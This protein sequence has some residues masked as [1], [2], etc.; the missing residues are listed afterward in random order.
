MSRSITAAAL[1]PTLGNDIVEHGCVL[2]APVR[3]SKGIH[4]ADAGNFID[5]RFTVSTNIDS[6]KSLI[7]FIQYM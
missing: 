6:N 1:L 5:G 4:H 2:Q 3:Q 7:A